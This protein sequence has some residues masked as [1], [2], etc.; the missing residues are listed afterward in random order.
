MLVAT[1]LGG[2][3]GPAAAPD[4]G[5]LDAGLDAATVSVVWHLLNSGEPA[6][7]PSGAIAHV[8]LAPASGGAPEML[9]ADC[10]AGTLTLDGLVAG[11]YAASVSLTD[12][13]GA[14]LYAA[15]P[16]VDVTA[17]AGAETTA[18]VAFDG[19]NGFVHLSW[20]LQTSTG[21]ATSCAMVT[22]NGVEVVATST[23]GW[24]DIYDCVTGE[25]PAVLDTVPNL[26]IG[27]FTIT[28][29][30]FDTANPPNIIGSSTPVTGT[31][32]YGNQF[33]DLGTVVVTL[34]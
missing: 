34:Q 9:D 31:I 11:Q 20:T 15:S 27:D 28:V 21:T 7:C 19:Y 23:S 3:S 8:R 22:N 2:C 16:P 6:A 5:A 18:D 24:V 32:D 33:I 10:D 17:T 4:A 1:I 13:T 29:N 26:P 25:L 12:P 30:V 14:T